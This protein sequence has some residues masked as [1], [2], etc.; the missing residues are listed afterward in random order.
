MHACMH[1]YVD[2]VTC[3]KRIAER[4]VEHSTPVLQGWGEFGRH[5]CKP[6]ARAR[7]LVPGGLKRR[8]QRD[9]ATV[10]SLCWRMRSCGCP[11]GGFGGEG[12]DRP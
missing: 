3:R 8:Q 12:I 4:R 5:G 6:H 11:P 10:V 7:G 9:H 1:G 2:I